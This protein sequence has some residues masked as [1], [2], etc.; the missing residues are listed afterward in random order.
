MNKSLNSLMLVL[1]LIGVVSCKSKKALVTEQ[2]KTNTVEMPSANATLL[3]TVAANENKFEYYNSS[4]SAKYKDNDQSY[5]FNVEVTMEKDKYVYLNVTAFLG[6]SVARL[7]F[8]KDS[9]C[10]LD[11]L[12]RKNFITNYHNLETIS[13]VPLSLAQVQ[14]VF[15]GNT[16]F[17]ADEQKMNADTILSYILINTPINA[18]QVQT[19][20]YAN[21][22]FK[23][24]RSIV[25]DKLT[26]RELRVEYAGFHNAG[27]NSFPKDFNIN[28]RAEKNMECR[29]NLDYFAFDKKKEV[30]FVVPKS[31]Q[32]V[33]M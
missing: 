31:F 23:V 32:N 7:W 26:G 10:I 24:N 30:K 3:K 29:M 25:A 15:I 22:T 17:L 19:T 11:I 12:H 2:A 28:I 18:Q 5:D 20:Y 33:R 21:N 9:I 13:N 4:G 14:K 8:T 1:L 16:I 6:I 27:L